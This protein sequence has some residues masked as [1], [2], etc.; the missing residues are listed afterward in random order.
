MIVVLLWFV[1]SIALCCFCCVVFGLVCGG[2]MCWGWCGL[3]GFVFSW[4]VGF[5]FLMFCL[6][7]L[8]L[9]VVGFFVG[10]CFGGDCYLSF[11]LC[12]SL[13]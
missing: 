10:W 3:C 5:G 1:Y 12:F 13:L 7:G 11:L 6:F 8:C 9:F 4:W 2:G